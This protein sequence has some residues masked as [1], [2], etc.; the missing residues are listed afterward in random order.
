MKFTN[1]IIISILVLLNNLIYINLQAQINNGIEVKVGNLLITSIDV[2]NEIITNL[3]VGKKEITQE[4][5]NN[6]KNYA[7]KNLI[8]KSIKKSEIDKY[9]IEDYR[10]KDL[11]NYILNVAKKLNTDQNGLKEI[12]KQNN[13]D[14]QVFIKKYE[15]ELLWNTLIYKLYRSQTNIN[16]VEVDNEVKK[17]RENKS[18][19]EIKKLKEDILNVKRE[20]KLNLFSRSHFSSLENTVVIDFQ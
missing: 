3:V 9:Q 10:E 8:S 7:V 15:I 17:F 14:Y 19:E 5:I 11:Q 12:F 4:N 16:L 6:S 13:I 1:L 20:K 18:A 2:Q